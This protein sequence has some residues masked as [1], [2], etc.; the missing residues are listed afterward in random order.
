MNN[1]INNNDNHIYYNIKI[2]G[3]DDIIEF[4]ENRVV[5]ILEKASDYSCAVCSFNLSTSNIPIFI[6]NN[7]I[8]KVSITYS[9]YTFTNIVDFIQNQNLNNITN[10]YFTNAIW[11]HQDFIDCINATLKKCFQDFQA[12]P[13]YLTIPVIDRPLSQPIMIYNSV[14]HRCSIY[15]PLEYSITKIN[16]IYV[17]FNSSL[18]SLFPAFQ[19][20]GDENNQDLAHYFIVKDNRNNKVVINSINYLKLTE[21]YST[22]FLWNDFQ[23]V[24][25]ETDKIPVISE[26]I[27]SQKNITRKIL[28]DFEQIAGIN[29]QSIF[30]YK[31]ISNLRFYNLIS[32]ILLI[33]IDLKIYWQAKNG[34][35]Y[36]VFLN[37]NDYFNI[38]IVFKKKGILVN[39]LSIF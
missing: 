22:L 1:K 35:I 32:N 16:P 13:V 20:Y 28:T 3:N 33:S 37:L 14:Y 12:S 4:S 10:L 26:M 36:P 21:E 9:T 29:D 34:R 8:F 19:N 38:K 23:S 27:A 18:F 31:P 17:Y 30:R 24:L 11:H 15:F 7:N 5:P 2:K 25:F 39:S 6:W